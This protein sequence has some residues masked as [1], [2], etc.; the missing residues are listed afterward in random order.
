MRRL[1][2]VGPPTR[3]QHAQL[4]YVNAL[5]AWALARTHFDGRRASRLQLR[6]AR[7][8]MRA[9]TQRLIDAMYDAGLEPSP[10]MTGALPRMYRS[11]S[12]AGATQ[13]GSAA[14]SAVT[15]E[16]PAP[17]PLGPAS[18]S[19]RAAPGGGVLSTWVCM[20]CGVATRFCT[21]LTARRS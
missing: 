12:P 14:S 11:N 10:Y 18:S 21:C 19:H 7:R 5:D 17:T 9:A 8:D 16:P 20:N 1:A 13:P 3:H 6:C 15:P 2:V 4:A